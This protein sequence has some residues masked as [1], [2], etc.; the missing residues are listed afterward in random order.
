VLPV[1][2]IVLVYEHDVQ[3]QFSAKNNTNSRT[4]KPA[5]RYLRVSFDPDPDPDPDP[6]FDFDY[7]GLCFYLISQ[8]S[9]LTT[10]HSP[11]T[12]QYK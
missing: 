5:C 11:L 6:D 2:Q 1:T 7:C 8:P 12:T 9:I 4:K 3:N 10:H